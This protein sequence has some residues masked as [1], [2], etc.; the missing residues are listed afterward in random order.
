LQ[1]NAAA[2]NTFTLGADGSGGEMLGVACYRRGTRIATPLGEIPVEGLRI[3]DAVLTASGRPRPIRWIGRR[4]YAASKVGAD[5][6]VQPIRI[7]TGAIDGRLPRRDLWVS[8]Q[9]ALLLADV[10]GCVL[11]PAHLLVNGATITREE[12]ARAITYIHIE[13]EGHEAILAEGQPAET[14]VD[15]NSR[16]M[17]DN[18]AEY[19]ALYPGATRAQARFCAPR[20]TGGVPFGR[21]RG[22]IDGLA[23]L[24]AGRLEGHIDSAS[25]SVMSGWALDRDN[26][27]GPVLLEILVDGVLV[28]VVLADRFRADL[29]DAGKG[30]GHCA[31]WLMLPQPLSPDRRHLVSIRRAL[32]GAD[33]VGGQMLIDRAEALQTL[34]PRALRHNAAG[35]TPET[36]ADTARF[37]GEQID[38]LRRLRAA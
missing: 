6:L 11:L 17:F 12:A 36:R 8:P 7:A 22:R 27:G 9:H 30:D 16:A 19:D 35:A 4:S 18:A 14:F 31:F 25:R 21:I 26:P 13:L 24:V 3:G 15:D 20:I 33:L 2:A 29:R 28:D 37:L 10:E 38:A 1:F 23:G 5:R 34:L 32:D